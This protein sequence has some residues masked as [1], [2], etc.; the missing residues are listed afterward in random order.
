MSSKSAPATLNM[1]WLQAWFV[2]WRVKWTLHLL[3][4]NI[5]LFTALHTFL[6]NSMCLR[7]YCIQSNST[8][9]IFWEYVFLAKIML[10]ISSSVIES[11]C[12]RWSPSKNNNKYCCCCS[13]A[14]SCPTLCIPMVCSTPCFPG[15]HYFPEIAQIHVHWVGDAV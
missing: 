15:L 14:K 11:V 5:T 6:W 13:A 3:L 12:C 9:Q 1:L 7:W 8:F 10:T 2:Q 4:F